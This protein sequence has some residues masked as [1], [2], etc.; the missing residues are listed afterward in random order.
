MWFEVKTKEGDGENDEKGS[1]SEEQAG[2]VGEAG[3]ERRSLDGWWHRHTS[4]MK[5]ELT[6]ARQNEI[7][8]IR[9]FF[10]FGQISVLN[11]LKSSFCNHS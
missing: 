10:S 6:L 7:C 11:L 4:N 1:E 3:E 8:E 5:R 9:R 2:E